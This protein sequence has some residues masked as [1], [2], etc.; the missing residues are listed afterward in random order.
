MIR[1]T[2]CWLCLAGLSCL[3]ACE[4]QPDVSVPVDAGKMNCGQGGPIA[5]PDSK[6][7]RPY[8]ER[9]MIT[10]AD[11][12]RHWLLRLPEGYREGLRADVVFA[13]H[14]ATSNA[15]TAFEYMNFEPLADRDGVILV[16]PDA[17]KIF[18]DQEHELASYWNSAWEAKW[19]ERDYDVDFVLELVELIK[20]EYCAGDFYAAGMSAG[21]DM[22][23]ALQCHAGS[24]FL[25]YA[26][27]TYRYYNHDECKD[28]PPRPILSFHGSEDK[29]VPLEGLGAPW[30]DAHMS[31]I[32]QSWAAHNSCDLQANEE[33]VSEEVLR[34]YWDNCAA[35]TEWYLIE[36]GGHTWPGS[37]LDPIYGHSTEDI[38]ATE[39][40]WEF[41]FE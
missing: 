3:S 20:S 22:T 23:T 36:G 34:Y 35:M 29:I 8:Q 7:Y 28:S 21:G 18:Y 25:S 32:M 16:Y 19:R 31:E 39:L 41:F 6:L 15:K 17:N 1:M 26:P 40:I 38:S 13:F 14:G 5:A 37:D 27:V 33:R 12:E 4:A 9:T 2:L 24:P 11:A 10:S 30:Y